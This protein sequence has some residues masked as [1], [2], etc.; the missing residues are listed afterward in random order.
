[1][2]KPAGTRGNRP[3]PVTAIPHVSELGPGILN[4]HGIMPNLI[5]QSVAAVEFRESC[6]I[7]AGAMTL[8]C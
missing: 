7:T 4:P 1:M 8:F 5:Y 6:K 2:L 3:L